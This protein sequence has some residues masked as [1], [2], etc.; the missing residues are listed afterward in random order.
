MPVDQFPQ[1]NPQEA[2]PFDFFCTSASSSSST[3]TTTAV[4]R[5]CG[6]G[7]GYGDPSERARSDIERDIAEGLLSPGEAVRVYALPAAAE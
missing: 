3:I 2:H 7:G 4:R 1:R 6:G 5:F